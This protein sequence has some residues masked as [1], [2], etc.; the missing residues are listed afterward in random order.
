M[1]REDGKGWEYGGRSLAAEVRFC[2]L[3]GL[4]AAF[5]I[6][7]LAAVSLLDSTR[8]DRF[9]LISQSTVCRIRFGETG[10]ANHA[11]DAGQ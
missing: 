10:L 4:I 7:S 5:V 6:C 8:L 3:R 2:S 11:S 1:S 9:L